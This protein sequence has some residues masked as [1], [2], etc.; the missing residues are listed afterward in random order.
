MKGFWQKLRFL[1]VD[2][3]QYKFYRAFNIQNDEYNPKN[4]K[5]ER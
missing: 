2:G 5:G 3:I 4:K 1:L